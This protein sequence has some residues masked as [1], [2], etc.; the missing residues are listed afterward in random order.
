MRANKK[1]I[2]YYIYGFKG[3]NNF[4]KEKRFIQWN[5]NRVNERLILKNKIIGIEGLTMYN[6]T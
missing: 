2:A 3:I 1:I 6:Q 4:I 5:K